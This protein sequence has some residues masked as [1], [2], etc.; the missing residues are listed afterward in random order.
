TLKAA[1]VNGHAFSSWEISTDG[2]TSLIASNATLQFIMASNLT[3]QVY[4]TDVTKPGVTV[5]APAAGGRLGIPLLT[6]K[7][8]ASDNSKVLEV[9]YQLNGASWTPAVSSNGWTNWTAS[10][11]LA[12]GTN[13]LKVFAMDEAGNRSA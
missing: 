9:L 11:G 2:L 12:R 6:A 4:F 7:G 1:A 8:L 13:V 10:M 3:L 5:V